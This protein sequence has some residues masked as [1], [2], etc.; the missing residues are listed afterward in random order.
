MTKLKYPIIT[1]CC[2]TRYIGNILEYYNMLTTQGYIVLAD[3]TPHDRQAEFDKAM[4]DKVHLAKIDM[5]D[6][7]HFLVRDKHMGESVSKEFE[8]AK[9]H[10]KYCRIIEI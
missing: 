2:S 1:L 4:V 6:E 9:Q 7:V 10:E 8:Y 5:A 3:L